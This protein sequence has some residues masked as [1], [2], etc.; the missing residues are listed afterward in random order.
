MEA[1]GEPGAFSSAIIFQAAPGGERL[2]IPI[3]IEVRDFFLWPLLAIGLG[4]AGGALVDHLVRNVR[5]RAHITGRVERIRRE[6][7]LLRR[8]ALVPDTISEI[9]NLTS[10]LSVIELSDPGEAAA[11]AGPELDDI[12]AKL[13]TLV[14]QKVGSEAKVASDVRAREEVV[15]ALDREN[16]TSEDVLLRD[17]LVAQFAR[18]K[19][20]L[21]AGQIDMAAELLERWKARFAALVGRRLHGRLTDL[22]ARVSAQP[23]L[24]ALARTAIERQLEQ[25]ARLLESGDFEAAA[26][27]LDSAV[28]GFEAQ[29]TV[30][31]RSRPMGPLV[32]RRAQAVDSSLQVRSLDRQEQLE[33]GRDLNFEV[34]L[35]PGIRTPDVRIVWDFDDGREPREGTLIER[36][37]YERHGHY[38]VTVTVT[39]AAEGTLVG[40]C[41]TSVTVLPG[42]AERRQIEA[43]RTV[44]GVDRTVLAVSIFI[45]TIAGMWTLYLGK[46]FGSLADYVTAVLWGFGIDAGVR[47]AA[48]VGRRLRLG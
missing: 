23:N 22:R 30:V 13:R 32:S 39:R 35:P 14:Q 40:R 20:E 12:D 8:S 45:A 41:N 33:T 10:R 24:A 1:L 2:S 17:D 26:S 43:E 47:G 48:E 4:V 18:I 7:R 28:D 31:Y 5:P 15:A 27:I 29:G 16:P 6:L 3:S 34:E 46:P 19:R 38:F 25:V 44:A 11:S 21:G 37:R 9:E 36:N 42:S